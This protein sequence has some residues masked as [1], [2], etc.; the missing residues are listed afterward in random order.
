M[1]MPIFVYI[2]I[3]FQAKNH[4]TTFP[5]TLCV[6][7]HNF[8]KSTST[9]DYV[10]PYHS[11]LVAYKFFYNLTISQWAKI[12]WSYRYCTFYCMP[13]K[14][15]IFLNLIFFVFF[16]FPAFFYHLCPILYANTMINISTKY[17]SLQFCWLIKFHK[18]SPVWIS[19]ILKN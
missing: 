18:T 13:R 2:S 16:F 12:N 8:P 15:F 5:S 11:I 17:K 3:H 7:A 9:E 14:F 6:T 10:G 4:W 1:I 19:L